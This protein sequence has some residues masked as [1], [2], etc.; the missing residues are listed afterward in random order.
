M[1]HNISIL[2]RTDIGLESIQLCVT[3][4]LTDVTQ[5]IL[6]SRIGEARRL[7]PAAPIE[8][9]LTKAQHIDPEALK[10]L[11]SAVAA[12]AMGTVHVVDPVVFLL[13]EMPRPCP[14]GG[15]LQ[16]AAV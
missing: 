9:D 6:R 3:G 16:S 8:V 7:D 11:R 5:Q 4:C 10:K 2:A 15:K 13:P 12:E 1:S 14:P